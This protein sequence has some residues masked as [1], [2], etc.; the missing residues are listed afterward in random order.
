MGGN[1]YFHFQSRFLGIINGVFYMQN[2]KNDLELFFE[3]Y[4]E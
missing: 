1:S 3:E 2:D 4:S